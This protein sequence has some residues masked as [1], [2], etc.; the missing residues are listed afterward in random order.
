MSLTRTQQFLAGVA[1]SASSFSA[2]ATN[3][4]HHTP[5]QQPQQPVVNT[6]VNPTIEPD[7]SNTN[8]F[9]PA[10]TNTNNN[11]SNANANG[12]AVN[13]NQRTTYR[14][15]ANAVPV[16]TFPSGDCG[17]GWG[18]GVGIIEATVG[19]NKTGQDKE[20]LSGRAAANL[21][22]AGIQLGDKFVVATGITTYRELYDAVNNASYTVV[23]NA[24]VSCA[25]QAAEQTIMNLTQPL[26]E[27]DCERFNVASANPLS[28]ITIVLNSNSQTDIEVGG[29]VIQG[30]GAARPRV[31]KP[32]AANVRGVQS[33]TSAQVHTPAGV[34][35][36]PCKTTVQV[37]TQSVCASPALKP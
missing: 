32:G 13:F 7:M 36:I 5:P 24:K 31:V 23:A 33:A 25:K 12:G 2:N 37:T 29:P 11:N 9:D 19:F 30:G 10:N 6:T 15:A 4:G 18:I 20:C 1:L 26:S 3:D 21:I 14:A 16:Y 8:N 22:A 35:D 17:S 27:D 34:L 28:G